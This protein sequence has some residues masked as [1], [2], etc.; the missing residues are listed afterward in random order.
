M[1]DRA[2]LTWW[3][4]TRTF[5]ECCKHNQRNFKRFHPDI[6]DQEWQST[7]TWTGAVFDPHPMIEVYAAF[8]FSWRINFVDIITQS[9]QTVNK[10]KWQYVIF[11]DRKKNARKKW[12]NRAAIVL[13]LCLPTLSVRFFQYLPKVK[14]RHYIGWHKLIFLTST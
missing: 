1:S 8:G 12:H 11:K 14:K 7:V 6:E 3:M 10:V 9:N 13:Q 5:L 2:W 4:F